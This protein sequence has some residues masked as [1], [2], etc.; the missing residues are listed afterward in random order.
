[1]DAGVLKSGNILSD[2]GKLDVVV[3]R[4]QFILKT[5]QG[6]VTAILT[7]CPFKDQGPSTYLPSD[8]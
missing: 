6:R 1:M 4:G 3:S 7:S 5:V 2:Y 8:R